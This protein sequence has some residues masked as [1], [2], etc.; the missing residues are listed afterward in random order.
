VI[1]RLRS[2]QLL[3]CCRGNSS[4]TAYFSSGWAFFLPY[5]LFY[6][7]YAWQKW[8][9]NPAQA[10]AG[11]QDMEN[12]LATGVHMGLPS[13]LHVYWALHLIHLILGALA[14]RC[15][16]QTRPS[17]LP[18]AVSTARFQVSIL[19]RYFPWVSLALIF[20]IPGIYLEWPSDPWEH[21]RRINEWQ[22][23]CNVTAH[24]SWRKSSYFLPYSLTS[25][26]TGL[27]QLHWL[28][29][30][31][32]GICLLLS[33]QY[34]RLARAVGLGERASFIFVLLNALTLGNNVFSFYR[35]YGLSSSI[36]AQIGAVAL[37]RIAVEYFSRP[38]TSQSNPPSA[39]AGTDGLRDFHPLPATRSTLLRS[40][41]ATLAL[42]PLIAFNHIQ[43]FGIAGLGVLAVIVW[44][45]IEWKRS[46]IGWLALTAIALS[47]ATV[48]WF[49][50]EPALDRIYHPHG[51]LTAWYGFNLFSPSSPAFDRALQILGIFGVIN[52]IIGLWLIARRNHIAGWLTLTPV[53]ALALPWIALPF[54]DAVAAN[55]SS[56]NIIT[57]QRMLFAV[58]TGLALVAVFSHPQPGSA[59]SPHHAAAVHPFPTLVLTTR[60][61]YPLLCIGLV[62][63]VVFAPGPLA[64]NRLWQITQTAPQDLQLLHF[65]EL[66]RPLSHFRES[67]ADTLMIRH[68][69]VSEIER[70]FQPDLYWN[71][72]RLADASVSIAE[73]TQQL[74]L[75]DGVSSNFDHPSA[76]QN[77]PWSDGFLLHKRESDRPTAKII[78]TPTSPSVP[79]I[80]LGGVAPQETLQ[81]PHRLIISSP[82]GSVSYPFSPELI[83]VS[84]YHRYQLTCRIRQSG[85][86]D[87]INYLAV[88]WYDQDANLLTSNLPFPHGA[89]RPAGWN[90]GTFS[91]FGIIG[92]PAAPDWTSYSVSFGPGASA[93]I[94]ANAAF[95]RVGAMLN[96]NGAAKARVELADIRLVE[97][98]LPPQLLL[99]A[100]SFDH[101]Y[102]PASTAARLSGHWAPQYVPAVNVGI[103]EIRAHF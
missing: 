74:D 49:P 53:L 75:F 39:P 93:A 91:Y 88:A 101:L 61:A 42:L 14:L 103:A 45:L 16:W 20:W 79:W 66:V 17:H 4:L 19:R 69:L 55:M 1:Q 36:L 57:F 28:N 2:L 3:S 71:S 82:I 65:V 70:V 40:G 41:G 98:N 13:L 33:W 46:M 52:L 38:R 83:P 5:L 92:R 6:L 51:W 100:P 25:H 80:T 87:A 27:V 78:F 94:P 96:F 50:R 95:A 84:R 99:S 30:Y 22:I 18:S 73:L 56:E 31:Y 15:W 21:L 9:V 11:S 62:S 37:T 68:P 90:N 76:H 24:S 47:A 8:P 23:L 67:N 10:G 97:C 7:L 72:S 63:A 102:T 81:A 32:V 43:G 64:Y 59:P 12:S 44:R 77:I 86:S 48:R 26:T 58:P 34:Y 35:Y 29:L 60:K 89:G 54:A 85:A